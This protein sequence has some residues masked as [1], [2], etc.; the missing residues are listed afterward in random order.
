MKVFLILERL[1]E[2]YGYKTQKELAEKLGVNQSTLTMWKTRNSID[3][4]VVFTKCEDIDFHWLITGEK[5][6]AENNTGH[7]NHVEDPVASIMDN[8]IV[9]SFVDLI[10]RINTLEKRLQELENQRIEKKK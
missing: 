9:K 10:N 7:E 6:Y 2:Y 8:E 5:K 3:W 1:R 4:D